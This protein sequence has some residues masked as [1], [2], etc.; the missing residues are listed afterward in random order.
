SE[1]KSL[2]VKVDQI[3]DRQIAYETQTNED[4]M[5]ACRSRI[6]RFGDECRR[7]MKHSREFFDQILE[8]ITRYER[9]CDVHPEYENSKAV[10]TIEKIKKIYNKCD[11]DDS[12]L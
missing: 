9:Y 10:L 5:D 7:D 4:K 1:I 12:F 2:N 3:N 8:D 11:E 6:L